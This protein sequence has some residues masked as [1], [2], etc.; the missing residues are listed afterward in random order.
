MVLSFLVSVAEVFPGAVDDRGIIGHS[1]DC[2][3]L[4]VCSAFYREERKRSSPQL[5]RSLGFVGGN[6]FA[7]LVGHCR[8]SIQAHVSRR[9]SVKSDSLSSSRG[10]PQKLSPITLLDSSNV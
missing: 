1:G 10:N 2:C 3:I 6:G 9:E 7:H 4:V 5:D 8:G